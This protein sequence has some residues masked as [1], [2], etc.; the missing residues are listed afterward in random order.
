MVLTIAW[1]SVLFLLILTFQTHFVLYWLVGVCRVVAN[2]ANC[3]DCDQALISN[4]LC[5]LIPSIEAR[6]QIYVVL[7]C[8]KQA[9]R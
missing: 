3:R 6:G 9:A 8:G 1:Y 7:F 5:T 2:K 4:A